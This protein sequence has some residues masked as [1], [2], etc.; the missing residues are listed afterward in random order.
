MRRLLL[1]ASLSLSVF[2]G[3]GASASPA[4]ADTCTPDPSTSTTT[5]TMPPTGSDVGPCTVDLTGS[6]G[7]AVVLTCGLVAFSS[8]LYLAEHIAGRPR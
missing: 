6:D 4:S 1:A 2:A 5:T 7:Q 8:G 3:L